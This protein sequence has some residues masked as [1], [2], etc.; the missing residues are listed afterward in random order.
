MMD[1]E[2]W[3]VDVWLDHGQKRLDL[4]KRLAERGG[5]LYGSSESIGGAL[6]KNL[7]GDVVPYK[8]SIPGEIVFWPYWRQTL[9]TSPQNTHSVLKGYK[10]L[11]SDV[12]DSRPTPAFWADL[13]TALDDLGRTS[14]LTSGMG[15]GGAKA[16][17]VLSAA[18]EGLLRAALASIGESVGRLDDVLAKL[19]KDE[20]GDGPEP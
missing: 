12:H 3:W 17:R 19:R 15:E 5:Q 18:N 14:D 9:S 1:D 13:R 6:V 20:T 8:A 4:V 10:A 7:G 2:G 11:L 16:G